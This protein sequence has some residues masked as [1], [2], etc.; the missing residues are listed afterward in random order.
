MTEE[1]RKIFDAL[2]LRRLAGVEDITL[3]RIPVKS[4]RFFG[5]EP[6]KSPDLFA[7]KIHLSFGEMGENRE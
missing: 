4:R 2:N 5:L 3:S 6:V 1:Q 7:D